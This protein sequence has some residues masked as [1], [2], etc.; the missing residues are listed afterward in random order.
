[1]HGVN[2]QSNVIT[3]AK[4]AK[5]GETNLFKLFENQITRLDSN[6]QQLTGLGDIG[7]RYAS[8]LVNTTMEAV[9]EQLPRIRELAAKGDSMSTSEKQ[10]LGQIL[11]NLSKMFDGLNSHIEDILKR[12]DDENDNG[13]AGGGIGAT[14]VNPPQTISKSVLVGAC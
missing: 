4:G 2:N 6:V 9:K 10:E 13:G 11:Q 1:M 5:V 8:K 7:S 14:L 3:A 12:K